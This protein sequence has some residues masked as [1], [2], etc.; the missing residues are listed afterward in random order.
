MCA[1][2]LSE[3]RAAVTDGSDAPANPAALSPF[4]STRR[5]R[6]PKPRAR[7]APPGLTTA[8]ASPTGRLLSSRSAASIGRVSWIAADRRS[9]KRL[10]A[11]PPVVPLGLRVWAPTASAPASTPSTRPGKPLADFR[12]E[13]LAGRPPSTGTI[14][15]VAPAPDFW[16]PSPARLMPST[17]RRRERRETGPPA[18]AQIRA[19]RRPPEWRRPS[20][21]GGGRCIGIAGSSKPSRAPCFRRAPGPIAGRSA[22]RPVRSR[23]RAPSRAGRERRWKPDRGVL[24]SCPGRARCRIAGRRAR[25][26]T[27][28]PTRYRQCGVAGGDD[29]SLRPDGLT[30]AHANLSVF[31]AI[32]PGG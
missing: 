26:R 4:S 24:T 12:F 14:S 2:V 15:P 20:G 21:P 31:L 8:M 1:G 18:S 17:E 22:V 30:A 29:R 10:A 9:S 27:S 6:C 7:T 25:P 23:R 28:A 5:R 32:G 13:S 11:C 16:F 19:R 3:R